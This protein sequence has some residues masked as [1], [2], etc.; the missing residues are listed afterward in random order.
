MMT[1]KRKKNKKKSGGLLKRIYSFGQFN[2]TVVSFALAAVGQY[3]LYFQKQIMPG[4]VFFGLAV[5]VFLLADKSRK[6]EPLDRT[7]DTIDPR[8]EVVL[9]LIIMALA[10][11]FRVHNIAD[12]P[13]GCYRDEGQNGN[14]AIN[15][16]KGIS[17]DGTSL[18]VYIERWTQNAAMYMYFIAASF[19]FFDIGVLQIRGVSIFFGVLCIPAFYFLVRHLMGPRTA[20]VGAFLMAVSRWHVNFSRIG[21]LGITTVFFVIVC[22]YFAYRAYRKRKPF[23]YIMLGALTGMS[24]YTYLAAR[25]IPAGFAIFMLFLFFREFKFFA[26]NWKNLLFTL[27]AM[28]IVLLPLLQYA[29]K[30][31]ANFTS[32][33]STVSI[34]NKEM[35]HEIGGRYTEKDGTPKNA[36]KLYADAAWNTCMMFNYLGDGNPRHNLPGKPMLDFFT[37]IFFT[38]GFFYALFNWKKPRYFL[39]LALFAAFLQGGMLS[40]ESP[41]AYRTIAAI[42]V[43]LLFA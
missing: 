15:I 10:V 22:V 17:V 43:V 7:A 38:L 11:Y 37:G 42:P 9:F 25:L 14:E 1:G 29:V 2:L 4:F 40:T 34:F 21:F 6:Q 12:L 3:F 32:R 19:N 27:A 31:P 24:L 26:K 5:L 18:P 28:L 16:M 39:L 35:L 20:L 33:Q 36:I 13:A 8:V 41:Q 30:H 23:D